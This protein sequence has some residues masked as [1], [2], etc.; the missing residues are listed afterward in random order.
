MARI[1]VMPT[2]SDQPHIYPLAQ[3]ILDL[4]QPYAR[5]HDLSLQ[6]VMSA[7]GTAAGAMLARAYNDG[8]T[9]EAVCDRLSIAASHMAKIVRQQDQDRAKEATKQ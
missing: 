9:A 5:K 4:V 1:E 8:E 7:I 2:E 3:E 6:A